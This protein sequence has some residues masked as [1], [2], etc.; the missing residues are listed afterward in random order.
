MVDID[1]RWAATTGLP[2][3]GAVLVRPDDFVA[4]RADALAADPA[5]LLRQVVSRML[6]RS[7]TGTIPAAAADHRGCIAHGGIL[8]LWDCCFGSRSSGG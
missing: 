1:G 3:D 5:K 7:A 4:W 8:A 6:H 2:P